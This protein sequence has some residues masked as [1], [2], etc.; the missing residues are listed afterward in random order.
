MFIKKNVRTRGDKSYVTHL[1]VESVNTPAGPRHRTICNL[2]HMAPGPKEEWL[3][4]AERIQ[5]ALAGQPS[6][7]PDPR[8]DE[9][10]SRVRAQQA[11][12]EAAP[13][14]LSTREAIP[15]VVAVRTGGVQTQDS[16][17]VGPVHVGHQMWQRLQMNAILKAAGLAAAAIKLTEV[18]TLNRLVHPDS[19]RAMVE[20]AKRVAVSDV[21]GMDVEKLN[22]DRFYR[23]MDKLHGKRFQ[24]E[25]LLRE[26][27]KSLFNLQDTLILYDL[28]NTYFE[29]E[30]RQIPKAKRGHSKEKRSDCKLVAMG[31]MV[32]GEGFPI[33]HE[34]M[35]GNTID[36]TTVPA[37]LDSLEARTGRR[38]GSTIVMDRGFASAA[39][40]ALVRKREHHYLMAGF[41]SQRGDLLDDFE[42][43]DGWEEIQPN[44][45]KVPV[46]IK[47][48][49]RDDEVLLLC[50]SAAR[51]EKDRAIR[52][53]QEGR[54]I[55][56]LEDL[57]KSVQ[58]A[59]EKG[60]PMPEEALG[61][62]IGR[63][64]ERYTRAARYYSV[65]REDGILTWALKAEQHARAQQLDGA[66]FLRTSN[67][68]LDAEDIWRTYITLTRIESAFRDLK[69]TLDL[70]PIHHRKETRV[71]THIFLCILAYHLQTAIERTLQQAGDH[72][73]WETLREELSTHQVVTITLPTEDG[74][75][76]AIR[77]G[78]IPDRRVREIY[79]LLALDAE[80]MKPLRTWI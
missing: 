79:R 65:A 68:T 32:D 28:T 71:E 1:L 8:V 69:G 33:G 7:Y 50:I 76:L 57:G 40:L 52:E 48:I 31:L 47:R 75:T 2:G 6:L 22:D 55:A 61:E 56:A 38:G 3:E 63:L 19:E 27:E 17:E 53:K 45:V 4:M 21:V 70:R 43:Q 25:N 29:G 42:A 46:Q 34:V 49:E 78:G 14:A 80:P 18:M 67:K 51:A 30:A 15:E 35:D 41:Q 58:K 12:A 37:M 44:A 26:R 39:N 16:R 11:K 73:S 9:V 23:N 59:A 24:I 74:R 13:V 5:A 62:R 54:L 36:G 66:Y 77:K 20:W 10:V 64:R 72:T 60:K